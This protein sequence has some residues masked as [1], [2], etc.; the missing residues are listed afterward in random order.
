MEIDIQTCHHSFKC[1]TTLLNLKKQYNIRT[2]YVSTIR[3]FLTY[4]CTCF[5]ICLLSTSF[6]PSVYNRF[7]TW[8]YI[9]I[10]IYEYKIISR[11]VEYLYIMYV[12]NTIIIDKQ[13]YHSIVHDTILPKKHILLIWW[14]YNYLSKLITK[15]LQIFKY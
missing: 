8:I 10:Y 1:D 5:H 13:N 15:C 9:Y 2:C 12:I 3:I 14:Y 11:Y 7:F 4:S 6:H